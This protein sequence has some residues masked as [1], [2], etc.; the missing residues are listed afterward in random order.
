MSGF[1]RSKTSKNQIKFFLSPQGVSSDQFV[2]DAGL[3]PEVAGRLYEDERTLPDAD[4]FLDIFRAFPQ[5]HP[6]ALTVYDPASPSF[7][8]GDMIPG[9]S[10]PLQVTI[11]GCGNLGHVFAGLLS[12][13]DDLRVNV[14]VSTPERAAQLNRAMEARGGIAVQMRDGEVVGR[15]HLVTADPARAVPGSRLIL[16]CVPSLAEEAVLER[17]APHLDPD[18]CV[19]SVPAPGGFDWKARHVLGSRG[20][21]AVVFGVGTIPWM[22]KI[23]QVGEAVTVLGKKL[24]NGVV[25]IP[26]DRT[27]EVADLMSHLSTMPVLDI[28]TF[29]NITFTP[30]NQILHPGIMYDMFQAWDGKPLPEQ[31]LFYETVSESAADLLRRMSGELLAVCRALEGGVPGLRLSAVMPLVL[32]IRMAY[33]ADVLDGST[34]R[35]AIATN[36]A[37]AGIRTPMRQVE[38]GWVP[39]FGSRF[40]WEDIPHGLV[41]VRGIADLV[42]VNTPTIDEVLTWAQKQMG[43]EYL[44]DGKLA[45]KDIATSGA[46]G[47]FGIART[48]DLVIEA[49]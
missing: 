43:R 36:R 5:V 38:G 45:G 29:L 44:V 31:P 48:E 15:P 37:Y 16:I 10:D 26:Q 25:V 8:A 21:R 24:N 46:P 9:G 35:S 6:L 13:R 19:G 28:R 20:Q 3:P 30:G 33:G 40:F 22:C 41:V 39:D 27:E 49:I 7:R 11:C 42:G 12:A 2:K 14:C 1:T 23:K 47:R 18:A 32:S 34:L 4:A 17:I